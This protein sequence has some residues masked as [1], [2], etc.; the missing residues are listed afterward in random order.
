M[1]ASPAPFLD[2][3]LPMGIYETLYAFQDAFGQAM[4]TEGTHP[5]SQGFPRT[6][7]LPG[8]PSIPDSV[9]VSSS[10]LKYPKAW[11]LPA[12]RES[13]AR[14]YRDAYGAPVDAENV[15]VFAGGRPGLIALLLFLQSDIRVRI[16]ETEY[17][18]YWDMLE[19]LNREYSVVPSG[20]QNGFRP[21]IEEYLGSS[22]EGRRLL[23][24]SNPCNPTGQ[25]RSGAE[26]QA[27]VDAAS[28]GETGLL[29]D[30]AYEFFHDQPV[31]ALAHISDLENSNLFVCGAA[32][33]GLQA[34]GIRVGWVVAAKNHI[35][36]LGNFAS[37]GMGGVSHL[38]QNY[39]VELLEPERTELARRAV[40][41][42]YGEMRDRYGEALEAMGLKLHSGNGGFYHWCELP[43]GMTAAGLNRKLFE[44]GAAIL[45]GT[46]CDMARRGPESPL[47]TFFRFSFG[48]LDPSTFDEDMTILRSALE[49]ERVPS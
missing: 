2:P 9:P 33:K 41:A 29:V 21:S 46:D 15:M 36:T 18:P 49:S 22:D 44:S 20:T 26:L 48:P 17:T 4:G 25:T 39:A 31:S 24:L 23:L 10:D 6:V 5:W 38:S 7:Q 8:G 19:L 34:P 14:S 37:F 1:N 40:S 28:Y 16:A 32:T 13:I 45:E 3:I 30:E 42:Y 12:L 35:E 11:G 27:L 43:D 47:A